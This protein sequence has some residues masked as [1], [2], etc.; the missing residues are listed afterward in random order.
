MASFQVEHLSYDALPVVTDI[1]EFV[2][3]ISQVNFFSDGRIS[4]ASI[5]LQAQNGFFITNTNNG[6]TPLLSN[7]DRIRI[8]ATD[9]DGNSYSHIFE[10]VD[11]LGQLNHRGGYL[12]P[13][14]LEGRER[15]LSQI[16]FSGFFEDPPL[17]H[18]AIVERILGTYANSATPPRQ[19]SIVTLKDGDVETNL[20][21]KYN[22]NIWDF[23]FIDN[24]LDALKT[25]I[26]LA[27]QS[28]TAGG[29]G[30]RYAMVFEDDANAVNMMTLSIFPQGQKNAGDTIPIIRAN[31][32]TN[33][34]I[35]ID[36]VKRPKTGTVV[37]ARGKPGT[38][39][40]PVQ[41]DQ[42]KARLEF[43][44]RI[45]A[46]QI[47][48][49]SITYPIGA[50][51]SFNNIVYEAI[52][53]NTNVRPDTSAANWKVLTIGEY[54]GNIQY[55]PF[56][57][58]KAAIFKNECTNPHLPFNPTIEDSPKMLDCNIFIDDE[59]TKRDFVWIR[60]VTDD[61]SQW[62][63][64]ERAY[65][66]RGTE[67]YNG[68]RILVDTQLGTPG[69]A[70]AATLDAYGTGPG[71]D[72][73]GRP[74]ANN[75]VVYN[76]GI[77]YVI[78]ETEDFDQIVVRFEGLFEWNVDF[79]PKSRYPG[80]DT[81]NHNHR[82][83]ISPDENP[84]ST[85]QWKELGDQF[86]ANDCLHSPSEIINIP[87]LINPEPKQGG[88]FYSDNSA[89]RI[90]YQMALE[91]ESGSWREIL[92]RIVG[93]IPG[94]GLLGSIF[95]RATDA[96]ANLFFTPNY[97]NAGWWMTLSSPFPFST[98]NGITEQVGQLYGVGTS[99]QVNVLNKHSTFD[100]YNQT[101]TFTGKNGWVE[102]DSTDMMQITGVTFLFKL[103][104]TYR[105]GNQDI[106]LPYEGDIPCSYWCMDDNGTIWKSKTKIGHLNDV[107]RMTFSFGDFKPVYRARTPF[108]ISNI[109][110]NLLGPEL[111]IRERL[112]PSRI[113]M[114]GFMVEGSYD[115]KGRYSPNIWQTVIKPT[116]F[117][118]LDPDTTTLVK[119]IGDIDYFQWVKT[120]IAISSEENRN[121][122]IVPEFKDYPYITNIEQLQR[123]ANADVDVET[124]QYEQYAI[125]QNDKADLSLQDS[126]YLFEKNLIRD[127][128]APRPSTAPSWVR[129]RKYYPDDMVRIGN[130][131]YIAL[132]TNQNEFPT[133]NPEEWQQL[134]N[135]IAN[136]RLLT[137]GEINFSVTQ[138]REILF[139]HILIRR[140]PRV[141]S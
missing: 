111:E 121:K 15:A 18:H 85:R 30:D 35:E 27:N 43:Y 120:P 92:D 52:R 20:L 105:Q 135:P 119:F 14:T 133:V 37:V 106:V 11:D 78:K 56:T 64:Q 130:A 62:S 82:F 129:T 55:S 127:A 81:S 46:S 2:H 140:I 69:G 134:A 137:V 68:F 109:I 107:G 31:E 93:F 126:V 98:H 79:P 38:G 21:P 8:S 132:K 47:W 100:I 44:Q 114:Q 45:Q 57:Q 4:T 16:P 33:P 112:F 136:T 51:V 17:S 115:D 116:I 139:K 110:T 12:L 96:L 1:T 84:P 48:D 23:L 53:Q 101:A 22:P 75:P 9:S 13:L 76:D 88:G 108:G 91:T 113:R 90:T 123:S 24:C 40:V 99:R 138:E 103:N 50:D 6:K 3:E 102:D 89:V 71:N 59:E 49:D 117:N 36:K 54:I 41:G 74:Y 7:A 65:L 67:I 70:F 77:W 122:T 124:F 34:I 25:V 5:V 131:I 26:R 32:L 104:I 95:L 97:R 128:E 86:L 10:I 39:G 72:P 125:T 60:E 80:S 61:T 87:G 19:P 73:N 28:V 58:D 118:L 141:T 63:T 29:T 83:R 66:F 42:Y 94:V